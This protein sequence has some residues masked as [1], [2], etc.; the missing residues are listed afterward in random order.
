MWRPTALAVVLAVAARSL[1][2]TNLAYPDE[3]GLLLVARQWHH[4]SPG[5]YG[6]LWVDRR[7][8]DRPLHDLSRRE[9]LAEPHAEPRAELAAVGEGAPNAIA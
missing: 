2:L 6:H 4:S 5:L 7:R 1:S 9:R 3:G 8:G